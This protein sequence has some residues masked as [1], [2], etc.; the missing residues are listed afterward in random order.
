MGEH[1][2]LLVLCCHGVYHKGEFYADYPNEAEFYKEHI[3]ESYNALKE[4]RYDVLIVSGGCT[5]YPVEKSEARGY[6]DWS[7]DLGLA[8]TGLVILEEYARS[9]VE[10]LLFSM[11]RFYQYFNDWPEEVGACTLHWKKDW[12]EK[13]I[14]PALCLPN[15]QVIV[16][17]V[18]EEKLRKSWTR[19]YPYKDSSEVA[20]EH[21]NDP[22]EIHGAKKLQERD[23]WKKGYSYADMHSGFAKMFGKLKQM[24][25]QGNVNADD[26]KPFYPWKH[27]E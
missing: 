9:S 21:A 17:K 19:H 3:R 18:E 25:E 16:P 4:G 26:L 10:N 11:C 5:K 24:K 6:L 14:A 20:K 8:R 23:F 15:F 2:K 27:K 7:D 1:K 22:L 12:F 13:V